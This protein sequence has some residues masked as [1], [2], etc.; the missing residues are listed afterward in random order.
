MGPYSDFYRRRIKYNY[1]ISD[2]K[3]NPVLYLEYTQYI[4]Y[5]YRYYSIV[6]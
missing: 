2:V 5:A 1:L 6:V 4:I 3:K